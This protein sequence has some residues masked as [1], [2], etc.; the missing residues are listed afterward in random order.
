MREMRFAVVAVV[1]IL[2]GLVPETRSIFIEV[3]SAIGT[4]VGQWLGN[5]LKHVAS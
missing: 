2:L 3:L 1:L 5:V 4:V